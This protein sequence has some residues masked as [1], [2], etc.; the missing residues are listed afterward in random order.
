V[1]YLSH[2]ALDYTPDDLLLPGFVAGVALPDMVRMRGEGYRLK[3]L[4]P[5]EESGLWEQG[6]MSPPL[7]VQMEAGITRHHQVD[8]AWHNSAPFMEANRFM[9]MICAAFRLTPVRETF[10]CHIGAEM[11]L[12]RALLRL[13][14]ELVSF[15]YSSFTAP[16][17]QTMTAVLAR[18]GLSVWQEK[19]ETAWDVF[20]RQQFLAQYPQIDY[21]AYTWAGIY[22]HVTG[23]ETLGEAISERVVEEAT[24]MLQPMAIKLLEQ[25]PAFLGLERVD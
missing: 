3:G 25:G 24:L 4:A 23:D 19:T 17:K 16:V 14:P 8:A 10:F 11:M 12:D 13:K 18:R 20:C 1:N 2:F 22:S 9:R 7:D 15:F 6:E 5:G 21:M